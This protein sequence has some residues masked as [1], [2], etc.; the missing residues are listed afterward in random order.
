MAMADQSAEHSAGI[1]PDTALCMIVRDEVVNSGGGI[2]RMLRSQ[3]PHFREVVVADTGSKDGTREL[4]D[5]LGM[6]FPQLRVCDHPFN[7]YGPSRNFAK[8]Q[9]R[10]RRVLMLDADQIIAPRDYPTFAAFVAS[11][12]DARAINFP[13]LY[14]TGTLTDVGILERGNNP[15]MFDNDPDFYYPEEIW[16]HVYDK[17]SGTKL[18]DLMKQGLYIPTS[19]VPIVEFRPPEDAHAIKRSSWYKLDPEQMITMAPSEVTSYNQWKAF[20]TLRDDP[21]FN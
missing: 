14:A 18:I 5:R 4:L 2:E 21:R 12:P 17:P 13:W 1:V 3:A 15:R 19:P 11:K 20:N 9:A 6:E 7:G 10:S 16:E 8:S